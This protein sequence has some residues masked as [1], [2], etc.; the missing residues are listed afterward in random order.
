MTEW[1][2]ANKRCWRC[3]RKHQAAQCDLKKPCEVCQGKHL[4]VLHEVNKRDTA[5]PRKEE[6]SVASPTTDVLYLDRPSE[7]PRVLLKVIKVL[8]S[9]HDR[10][11]VTYAVLD[12]GSEHTMPLPEAAKHLGLEGSPEELGLRTIRQDVQVLRGACVSFHL[13]PAAQP[14]GTF[15]VTSAFTSQH[16]NLAE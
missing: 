14:K 12:D 11:L 13:S 3:A 8:L 2:K 16:L 7:S 4:K 10:K 6:N 5:A 15:K 1:I 9:H